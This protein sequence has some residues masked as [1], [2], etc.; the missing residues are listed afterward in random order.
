MFRVRR[1]IAFALLALWLPATMHCALEAAGINSAA[2]CTEG[3]RSTDHHDV[4]R[5]ACDV[6]ESGAFKP[7]ADTATILPPALLACRLCFVF[8][9]APTASLP[10]PVG[11][12]DRIVSPPEVARTWHFTARAALP[13]RAPSFASA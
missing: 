9:T 7:A 3:C 6:V 12:S 11:V 10:P 5:D 2:P 4:P 1:I 8:L 13:A